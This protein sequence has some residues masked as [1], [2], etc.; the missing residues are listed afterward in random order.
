[1]ADLDKAVATQLANIEKRTGKSLAELTAIVQ[2]SRLTRHG[3]IVAMLKEQLGMGHG[4]ANTLV[5]TIRKAEA[6]GAG[7]G[8]AIP[9]QALDELYSGPKAALRSI[10]EALLDAIR[11]FGEFEEAPKKA[12]IS[13]RRK[14]QF[15]TIGPATKTQVEVGLNAKGL[16]A[17]G[18]LQELPAGQMC[19]YRI[20]LGHAGEVDG[21]LLGWLRSAY[22]ASA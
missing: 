9:G 13:Y 8:P 1:M 19:N 21:E 4:D 2:Q 12:Y 11:S 14:K 5:H 17:G 16:A 6:A 10:H 18:R 3:E 22:D 7:V 15:A 20:R